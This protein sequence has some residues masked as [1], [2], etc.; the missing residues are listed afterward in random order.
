MPGGYGQK[1]AAPPPSGQAPPPQQAPPQPPMTM[2]QQ[3][4]PQQNWVPAAFADPEDFGAPPRGG[5]GGMPPP[6]TGGPPQAGMPPMPPP[7]GGFAPMQPTPAQ[8]VQ[9][10]NPAAVPQRKAAAAAPAHA[11]HPPTEQMNAMSMRS[12]PA[13]AFSLGDLHPPPSQWDAP[14]PAYLPP[15]GQTPNRYM[16]MR[17]VPQRLPVVLGSCGCWCCVMCIMIRSACVVSRT[18]FV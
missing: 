15:E 10:F 5:P 9:F 8:P 12:G 16:H 18:L 14:Q 3:S 11:G 1:P 4:A 7:P 17:C 13:Q 2:G 6:P